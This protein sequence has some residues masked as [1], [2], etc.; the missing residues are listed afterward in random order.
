MAPDSHLEI[1]INVHNIEYDVKATNVQLCDN[2]VFPRLSRLKYVFFEFRI[3]KTQNFHFRKCSCCLLSFSQNWMC[4]KVSTWLEIEVC[5]CYVMH[6]YGNAS[7]HSFLFVISAGFFLLP[8]PFDSLRFG[9]YS[10]EKFSTCFV[11]DYLFFV[12]QFLNLFW[13]FS[14]L[15]YTFL[16]L[17][18][19]FN[20]QFLLTWHI[21]HF[22]GKICL[23]TF[24]CAYARPGPDTEQFYMAF[25]TKHI[26]SLVSGL[27]FRELI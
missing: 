3:L 20:I 13:D 21:Y 25:S 2:S 19:E 15:Y 5:L 10:L 23:K 18:P 27:V 7:G 1:D 16:V 26:I 12:R 17:F 9:F 11:W 8:F 22:T 24:C 14:L 6:S 4:V